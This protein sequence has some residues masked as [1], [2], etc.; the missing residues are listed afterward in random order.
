MLLKA[1]PIFEPTSSEAI[2]GIL[3][4]SSAPKTPEE[5]DAGVLTEAR[6]RYARE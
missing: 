4:V 2:F 5:M 1:A 6:R 3:K